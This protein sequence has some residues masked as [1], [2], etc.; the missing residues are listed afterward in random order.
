MPCERR[1]FRAIRSLGTI[2]TPPTRHQANLLVSRARP[3]APGYG[4]PPRQINGCV[5]PYDRV[6]RLRFH[7]LL[8]SRLTETIVASSVRRGICASP[9]RQKRRESRRKDKVNREL[10]LYLRQGS[11]GNRHEPPPHYHSPLPHPFCL[12]FERSIFPTRANFRSVHSGSEEGNFAL[13]PHTA[14]YMK[15]RQRVGNK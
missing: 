13:T 9:V 6:R 7:T 5:D 8:V 2:P 1:P 3:N 14:R 10:S 11:G 15:Q 12:A 4:G